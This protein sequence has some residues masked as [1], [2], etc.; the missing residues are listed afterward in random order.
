MSQNNTQQQQQWWNPWQVA[1]SSADLLLLQLAHHPRTL[2]AS[3][4]HAH[5]PPFLAHLPLA[6]W[7]KETTSFHQIGGQN[8][9]ILYIFLLQRVESDT[10]V[11]YMLDI[12]WTLILDQIFD[13]VCMLVIF[14]TLILDKTFHFAECNFSIFFSSSVDHQHLRLHGSLK[15]AGRCWRPTLSSRL[16]FLIF[17]SS[18]YSHHCAAGQ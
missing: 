2:A 6:H 3:A 5:Q 15:V 9:F 11:L 12:F 10:F 14:W 13:F 8:N 17:A 18:P 7:Q 16:L 4:H 1:S